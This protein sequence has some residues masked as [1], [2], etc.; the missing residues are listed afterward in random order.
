MRQY[1][2][3]DLFPG[4]EGRMEFVRVMLHLRMPQLRDYD[5][6]APLAPSLVDKLIGAQ[7]EVRNG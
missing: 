5:R 2:L 6:T 7:K 4:I 3:H 1:T